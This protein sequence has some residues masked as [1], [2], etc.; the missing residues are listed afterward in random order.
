MALAEHEPVALRIIRFGWVVAQHASEV[1]RHQDVDR[2]E[3]TAD[4]PHARV[5]DHLQV[6]QAYLDSALAQFLN[7]LVHSH[8]GL[9]LLPLNGYSGPHV[10]FQNSDAPRVPSRAIA[11]RLGRQE[12]RYSVRDTAARQP[13]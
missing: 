9:C 10:Q 13:S 5:M 6:P 3:L 4:V 12:G 2:R 7:D 8:R 1:E 11:T